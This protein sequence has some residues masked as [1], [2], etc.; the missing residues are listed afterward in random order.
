MRTRR[1]SG[2]PGEVPFRLWAPARFRAALSIAAATA[3]GLLPGIAVLPGAAQ[4]VPSPSISVGNGF[5]VA[6]GDKLKYHLT[7]TAPFDDPL[8]VHVST[9]DGTATAGEDYTAL[10]DFEVTFGAGEEMAPFEVETIADEVE[11][12]S[13]SVYVNITDPGGLDV[14]GNMAPMNIV[15]PVFTVNPV[16]VFIEE[17]ADQTRYFDVSLNIGFQQGAE[18][19]YSIVADGDTEGNGFQD[20]APTTLVF[21]PL[22]TTP[23]TRAEMVL[24]GDDVHRHGWNFT[25]TLTEFNRGRA[26]GMEGHGFA[27]GDDDERPTVAPVADVEVTEGDNGVTQ[28]TF[29]VSLSNVTIDPVTLN[30]SQA[31]GTAVETPG[32]IGG[33]DFDL[34][35]SVTIPALEQ[36]A[37]FTVDVTGDE[38][39]EEDETAE[40]LIA[41]ADGD[42][43]VN[44]VSRTAALKINNDDDPPAITFDGFEHSEGTQGIGVW[45]T[46]NGEAQA[47]LPWTAT[48]AGASNDIVP[49]APTDPAEPDDF[50]ASALDFSGTLE[51]GD[52]QIDLGD[53]DLVFDAKD[54]FDET[55][56]ATVQLGD[57][58]PVSGFATVWDFPNQEEAKLVTPLVAEA[59]EGGRVTIPVSLDFTDNNAT[60]TEKPITLQYVVNTGEATDGADYTAPS[61]DLTIIS[62]ATS[63]DIVID[64]L[65]D[66]LVEGDET[67]SVTVINAENALNTA[68]TTTVTIHDRVPT[69]S[70]GP[71]ADVPEGRP[72]RFPITLSEQSAFDQT[73]MVST[74]AG[75]AQDPSDYTGLNAF[76]VVIPAGQ[77]TAYAEVPTVGDFELELEPETVDLQIVN[78][79]GAN[80]VTPT[81]TGRI[82]DPVIRVVPSPDAVITEGD[83]GT[84]N[85]LFEV[86]LDPVMDAQVTLD[87]EVVAGNAVA[88][89]D[90]VA[91]APG[92]LVFEP[93]DR[94]KQIQVP[95]HGDTIDEGPDQTFT[96]RL[97][98][99]AG[100]TALA[101]Q[102]EFTFT[103]TDDDSGPQG[104]TT[105][106][107]DNPGVVAE[108]RP[109][110]FPLT[111]SRPSDVPV[112]VRVSTTTGTATPGDDYVPMTDAEVTFQPGETTAALA[113]T[114]NSD[115]VFEYDSETVTVE[116]I[117]PGPVDLGTASAYGKIADP[118]LRIGSLAIDENG[119]GAVTVDMALNVPMDEQ[120][121]ANYE[122]LLGSAITGS[123]TQVSAGTLTYPPGATTSQ[124]T[125]T[126]PGGYDL[127]EPGRMLKVR[128]SNVVT[129]TGLP[130]GGEGEHSTMLSAPGDPGVT[131]VLTS[132]TSSPQFESDGQTQVA[133]TVQLSN[134][135]SQPVTLDV[136]AIDGSAVR[137][138]AGPGTPDFAVPDQVTFLPGQSQATFQVTVVGDDVFERNEEAQIVVTPRPGDPLVTGPSQQSTLTVY[139]DDDAPTVTFDGFDRPEGPG[140]VPL[141]FSVSGVAQDPMPW[142]AT[143]QGGSNDSRD[144][145]E[146]TDFGGNPIY[147]GT[148]APG[149]TRIDMGTLELWPDAVDEYDEMIEVAVEVDG[150]P[151]VRGYGTIRDEWS[152]MPPRLRLPDRISV[153]EGQ[154]ADIPVTLDFT[155]VPGNTATRTEKVISADYLADGGDAQPGQDYHPAGAGAVTIDPPANGTTISIPTGANPEDEPDET[156]NVGLTNLR[157]AEFTGPPA[158]VT[159][160]ENSPVVSI[161]S[162]G[163]VPEGR[164]MRFPLTL[165]RPSGNPVTV[166]FTT[167]SGT[168]TPGADYMP[169]TGGEVTFQP[170]QTTAIAFVTTNP[171]N[172]LEQDSESVTVEITDPGFATLGTSSAYGK[173]VDPMLRIG[174]VAIDE[175]VNRSVAVDMFLSVQLDADVR[176]DYELLFGDAT[177]GQFTTL[178]TGV[179]S[180]MPGDTSRQITAQLPPGVNSVSGRTLK[181][182]LSNVVNGAGLP[183]GGEGEHAAL[184]G[185]PSEP[186]GTAPAIASVSVSPQSESDG[187]AQAWA[188]VQLTGP[189]SQPATLDVS[190]VDGSATRGD[191]AP[192][193]ND[194]SVP[195]V[196]TIPAGGTQATFPVTINGDDVF[197]NEEQ[198]Q[199]VVTPRPGDPL[200]TGP[201]QQS[202]LI[203]YNDD[204]APT[205]TFDGFDR[206]EGTGGVPVGFIVTGVAQD[207]MPWEAIV[208]GASSDSRDPAEDTDF[209]GNL[210]LAGT[211]APGAGR[212]DLGT[213]DLRTDTADEHDET[214]EAWIVVGGG[215]AVTGY[216]TIR[217]D[218]TQMPPRLRF[219]ENVVVSEG[220]NAELPIT[221]DF[222]A[223]PGNTAT[224]TEKVIWFDYTTVDGSA[225]FDTDFTDRGSSKP[226]YALDGTDAILIQTVG[227]DIPEGD[228]SFT[229][230]LSNVRNAEF[231]GPPPTVT[232]KEPAPTLTIGTAP[233]TLAGQPLRFPVTLSRPSLSP[234]TVRY[235]TMTTMGSA[236]PG[237]D[238]QPVTDAALTIP[239]GATSATIVVQTI[240]TGQYDF[241]GRSLYVQITDPG[242]ATIDQTY[243][244]AEISDPAIWVHAETPIVEGGPGTRDQFVEV[245]LSAPMDAP[246]DVDYSLLADT[247]V[248]GVDFDAVSGHLTFAPGDTVKQI[249]VPIRG[250]DAPSSSNKSFKVRLSN[251]T[252][253]GGASVHNEGEFPVW[254]VED[255]NPATVDIV[256]VSTATRPEGDSVAT[257]PVTVQLSGPVSLDTK[258]LVGWAGGTAV[259][260]GA[261][262][263]ES[264]YSVPAEVTVAAGQ[265][266]ATINVTVNGDSVFEKDEVVELLVEPAPNDALI[267]HSENTGGVTLVNDDAAPRVTFDGFEQSEG[268]GGVGV[269]FTVTGD[270]QDPMPWT[271]VVEGGSDGPGDPAEATDFTRDKLTLAGILAPGGDQIDVGDL[272]F[273]MD[274]AD[275]YDETIK[276]AVD[277]PGLGTT[278][279][280]GKI[281]DWHTQLPPKVVASGPVAVTEGGTA[282]V[283]VNLDFAAVPGNT[284]TSTEK[285][286]TV[287]YH[288]AGGTATAGADFTSTSGTLVFTPPATK[289]TIDVPALADTDV[290]NDETLTVNLANPSN[291]EIGGAPAV[292]TIRGAA[293]AAFHV[294]PDVTVTE[295]DVT[296]AEFTVTLDGPAAGPVDFTVGVTDGT[297]RYDAA[298]PGGRD[299]GTPMPTLTIP[300]GQTSATLRVP[301]VDDE[302]FERREVATVQV[303]LAP[304]ETDAAGTTQHSTLTVVDDETIP[305]LAL[306][307]AKATEGSAVDV[308]AIPSGVAQDPI[309]YLLSFNGDTAPGADSAEVD[310][311]AYSSVAVDL[312]AGS[313]GPVL[314]RSVPLAPD[315]IDEGTESFTVTATNQTFP[316]QVPVSATMGILDDPADLPPS[317]TVFPANVS[318]SA[319]FAEVL[320]LLEYLGANGADRTEQPVTLNYS[321]MPGTA[322]SADFGNPISPN[323]L[324][325]TP[326]QNFATIRVP[327]V[328]DQRIENNES[329]QVRLT[330]ILPW[331]GGITGATSDVTIADDDQNL[332]R[333]TFTVTGDITAREDGGPATATVTLSQAAQG[334]VD[335]TVETVPGTATPSGAGDGGT[336]FTP[337]PA[338]LRIP[339]GSLTGTISIPIGQDTVYEGDENARISVALAPGE[340]DATGTAQQGTLT[341]TDDEA[342]PTLTLDPT[343]ATV[344]E[345]DTVELSGTVKGVA[346]R[347]F[348]FDAG[349]AAGA[350]ATGD[351][352]GDDD[353]E[354]TQAKV[355]VPG[356]TASGSKVR[357]G[358]V[359]FENDSIDEDTETATVS[360]GGATRT[361]KITDDPADVA[362][363]V[364]IDDV[365]V[366]EGDGTAELTVELT[367]TGGTTATSRTITIPWSTADGTADAGKD[368]TKSSGTARFAPSTTTATVTVP[369]LQDTQDETDQSFT[370]KLGS[371]SPADVKVATGTATVTVQD[372]DK[373][374]APTLTPPAGTTNGSGRIT[375]SGTAG[376]GAKV[377]LLSAPGV[378]GGTFKVVST[379]QADDDG[380][381]TFKPNLTQ[382]CRMQTRSGGL[383]S[384]VR[385]IQLRQ[386]PELTGVSSAKGS[387]TL[388]VTG[389]PDEPGQKVTIQEQVRGGWDEVDDGKLNASGKFTTTLK[390]LKAG[391]HVYRAV[392][393]ATP[394]LGI[395]A[396]T[397]PARPVKVK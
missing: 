137:N 323:P 373:P 186:G 157:N 297:A 214:V 178:G 58:D 5:D 43:A 115:N 176:A 247:A 204:D 152:E 370:V 72:L 357:V 9:V 107:I 189:V 375:I 321:V 63:S 289:Q 345:G 61:G 94:V 74:V 182:R 201:A 331:G 187:P 270:A 216:G 44:G 156:F 167:T 112:T 199:I 384:P 86:R 22:E 282:S 149:A 192:G 122:L 245:H 300:Q 339:E 276:V 34:P 15:D 128:L 364:S 54:E 20:V 47:P 39:F 366:S 346:Q 360:I 153:A 70:V 211:V 239:A 60:A 145:A 170:G 177:T 322:G 369:I 382:G 352:A 160:T 237:V 200:V 113:V 267:A 37:T 105:V 209:T 242:G 51:P 293:A 295:G 133:F 263:G 67:F 123:F 218:P 90:F 56:K 271:A 65:P 202:T 235:S 372:D 378:S 224:T 161:A 83:S 368:Y 75:T 17:D 294:T 394:A 7:R 138:G 336:D 174:S 371:A 363:S 183:V 184:L 233:P 307:P 191:A 257:V 87:Y 362:P 303:G 40:I 77:T 310:D 259:S 299:Y 302:V 264:D 347:D 166:R 277:V 147:S 243:A 252:H 36:S 340:A 190:A 85:Q 284:A 229:V 140:S 197:E 117:N 88:G 84:R 19:K 395:T 198:A 93:G 81:A 313:T 268:A 102:G 248:A 308:T 119:S 212:I 383:T 305:A 238:Y 185:G 241:E 159:I 4:A 358:A 365:S 30:L 1:T 393:S 367:F 141:G 377:E 356:G 132:V 256:S 225:V 285:L 82:V 163:T 318:E 265:S 287:D 195:N 71:A 391:N 25:F 234:I 196:V 172:D 125:A 66:N 203:I 353:F 79:A 129:A 351:T 266:T 309:G 35:D 33:F 91:P 327:I 6:E 389:N 273:T 374:K 158:I 335:L 217:D 255:D 311:Y 328:N 230:A 269:W 110:V 320:V 207:P 210:T 326:G 251:V 385:T 254:I 26:G 62:P 380:A 334:D 291:A 337:P 18:V 221:V 341:I 50:D 111:L 246:V 121:Q 150:R 381:Y 279:G 53:V 376:A 73:I 78:A 338:T 27:I 31:G 134:P 253:A 272:D 143:V 215:N 283:P 92:Q 379:V 397:S 96:I 24:P 175:A 2:T 194:Y 109:L 281:L 23:T 227:D 68:Q 286:V 100:A 11:E 99:V 95:I 114:T 55:M 278:T 349:A 127:T 97:L 240:S 64:T 348:E 21:D 59:D 392:I 325:F 208:H 236:T 29:T 180:Y 288:T 231:A 390:N 280:Q 13:E 16:G 155:V 306:L 193:R 312:P 181:V 359:R 315:T 206:P 108:G 316:E 342:K 350:A 171:D 344:A 330:G 3:T 52:N 120:V 32:T 355:T 124:I 76:E 249:R 12:T 28:A 57:A 130:V 223:V 135:V 42:P 332:P 89:E 169:V 396:G 317:A 301:I 49:L 164:P 205:V 101:D 131:P 188:T 126:L 386:D 179:L 106:S 228:E 292:V 38:V 304:G 258:L 41:P 298:G 361:F 219:P 261:G 14:S 48:F 10:V 343:A 260:E 354:L 275:E 314:L 146:A 168:A 118:G 232:I 274:S 296:A 173:I 388:T 244:G 324:V 116:I 104:P 220:E 98:N 222:A 290:E 387:V 139:D 329:F 226:L 144:P 80:P 148:V 213:V 46:V 45:F 262:V 319:G 69:V 142:S 154:P 151:S 165:S 8:T 103:I 136:S 250:N 333:P 162:P